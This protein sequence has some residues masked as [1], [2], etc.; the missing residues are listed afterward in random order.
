MNYSQDFHHRK[1]SPLH[2]STYSEEL[3]ATA[4][5]LALAAGGSFF[6]I[7][8]TLS[9]ANETRSDEV[10]R[11][12]TLG[13][14]TVSP[15]LNPI[16]PNQESQPAQSPTPIPTPIPT[17]TSAPSIVQ[18]PFGLGGTHDHEEYR[19]TFDTPRLE[20]DSSDQLSRK[21]V[22]DIQVSNRLADKSLPMAFTA[23]IIRD[24]NIIVPAAAMSTPVTESV[25][26][27]QTLEVRA[28]LSL[29]ESTDVRNIYYNP[30]DDLPGVIHELNP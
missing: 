23:S 24:G 7:D 17:P 5:V 25:P 14:E 20:I 29:I 1:R 26:P 28:S 21:F 10:I 19:I 12:R 3:I 16:E 9:P 11:V 22:V 18:V 8:R 27:G 13:A 4:L 30:D 2:W 6:L 15:D